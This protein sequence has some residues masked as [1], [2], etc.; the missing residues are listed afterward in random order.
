[1]Q[2]FILSRN[3]YRIIIFRNKLFN[4]KK[5]M[6]KIFLQIFIAVLLLTCIQFNSLIA[7]DKIKLHLHQPPPNKLGASDLWKLDITNTTNED[8]AIYLEGD[9]TE[10][11]DGII[12]EGKSKVLTVN[13]GKKTYG[14]NDFKS[15]QVNWKNKTYEEAILRTGNVKSGNYTICVTAFYEDG[16]IADN[17]QCI[18]QTIEQTSEGVITLIS[19]SDG[20]KIDSVSVINFVWTAAGLKGP[21]TLTI[22]EVRNGQTVEQAFNQNRTFFEKDELRAANFLYPVSAPKFEKGKKYAWVISA[23]LKDEEPIRSGIYSFTNNESALINKENV[24]IEKNVPSKEGLGIS[25]F[26]IASYTIAVVSTSNNDPVNF[27]GTGTITLWLGGPTINLTYANLK[28]VL[29]GSD[30]IVVNGEIIQTINETITLNGNQGNGFFNA[31]KL[32]LW[33]NNQGQYGEVGLEEMAAGSELHGLIIWPLPLAITGG[34]FLLPFLTS[35]PAE[36]S[37][38]YN[39]KIEGSSPIAADYDFNLAD[40]LDFSI[41]IR[42]S[43]SLFIVDNNNLSFS[44]NGK[45]KLPLNTPDVSGN[46]IIFSFSNVSNLLFFTAPVTLDN[47]VGIRLIPNTDVTFAPSEATIDFS[48]TQSPPFMY[49]TGTNT[50][51]FSVPPDW[52]GV[53]FNK[54]KINLPEQISS[55]LKIEAPSQVD[56]QLDL[57]G[58]NV[59]SSYVTTAGLSCLLFSNKS[60]GKSEYRTFQGSLGKYLPQ[61]SGFKIKMDNG[62]VSDSYLRGFAKIPFLGD[63]LIFEIPINQNGL[64]PAYILP[65][66]LGKRELYKTNVSMLGY[67]YD[68]ILNMYI[69]SATFQGMDQLKMN[70]DFEFDGKLIFDIDKKLSVGDLIVWSSGLVAPGNAIDQ[71]YSLP[72]PKSAKF[73]KFSVGIDKIKIKYETAGNLYKLS[74]GGGITLA[75]NLPLDGG[76]KFD[77]ETWMDVQTGGK[78]KY[79]STH[80]NSLAV[81]C[82]TAAWNFSVSVNFYEND[83]TYGDG[84][85]G[86]LDFYIKKPNFSADATLYIGKKPSTVNV[87]DYFS[88]WFV[89]AGVSFSPGIDLSATGVPITINGF[90]GRAYHHMKHKSQP[91]NVTSTDFEPDETNKFGLMALLPISLSGKDNVYWGND[92]FEISFDTSGSVSQVT[93]Y[94]D[95]YLLT[96]GFGNKDGMV[97]LTSSLGY[98]DSQPPAFILGTLNADLKIPNKSGIPNVFCGTGGLALRIV[99]GS[100]W[101]FNA[102]SNDA[103]Q[104]PKAKIKLTPFCD[105][106]YPEASCYFML[107]PI[108]IKE[109][110]AIIF[111]SGTQEFG[112]TSGSH[113]NLKANYT[114]GFNFNADMTIPYS[115]FSFN[116][117]VGVSGNGSFGYKLEYELPTIPNLLKPW[118]IVWKQQTPHTG[119]LLNGNIGA[120]MV[121]T[122]PDPFC[123][124]GKVNVSVS[125]GWPISE[126]FSG[127]S[128]ENK[129]RWKNGNFDRESNCP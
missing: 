54:L 101:Y 112:V 25:H 37:V 79:N 9:L 14:Y 125:F 110:F 39:G 30:W 85:K 59:F 34:G 107:N 44:F 115:P 70:I 36:L 123:V 48:E 26:N 78:L 77:M 13:P 127:F 11:K 27:S 4:K 69:N 93:L 18:N 90:T 63:S 118:K 126:V 80:V 2:L 84:F 24:V 35:T 117:N 17:E 66:S 45:I 53:N 76:V 21:Y 6:N 5:V 68:E 87:N 41:N 113:Y 52:K 7:G 42:Q 75:D 64:A 46:R 8:I 111:N 95:A 105:Q 1:M 102:G 32:R 120:N 106:V 73:K 89:Q 62:I 109:G 22:K 122:F 97:K 96:S 83:P 116:G 58:G 60:F 119:T 129:M 57:F 61:E 43:G 92:A 81:S 82:T 19:P 124:A 56:V 71:W 12:V 33:A 94:Q 10:E 38:S 108:N 29:F 16:N 51:N 31:D 86:D 50:Y 55:D 100:D 74:L 121:F 65:A 23:G 67:Q 40:P 88:Y 20:E 104:E 91:W 28:L 128:W 47:A 49:V 72:T 15:G 99:N 3:E 103:I 114:Y 98:Y